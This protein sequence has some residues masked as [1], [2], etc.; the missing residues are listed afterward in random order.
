MIRKKAVL[1]DL[2]YRYFQTIF[3]KVVLLTFEFIAHKLL[4]RLYSAFLWIATPA[5]V[6][7]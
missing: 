5:D 1:I 2:K 7:L 3:S 4:V 6:V